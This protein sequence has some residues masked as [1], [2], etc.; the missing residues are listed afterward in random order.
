M[1]ITVAAAAIVVLVVVASVAFIIDQSQP[2]ELLEKPAPGQTK[3]YV[4]ANDTL[5]ALVVVGVIAI[6]LAGLL[7]WVIARR[8]VRPLGE[9]LRMQ[10]TF[11]A[12]A[13]HE[14]RTPVAVVAARAELLRQEN[15][16]GVTSA[17]TVAELQDDVRVLGDVITDLLLAVSPPSEAEPVRRIDVGELVGHTVND[18]RILA[19]ERGVTLAFDVHEQLSTTVPQST[20]RRCVV[21]LVDNAVGHSPSGGIVDVAVGAGRDRSRFELS[22]TDHGTGIL[23]IELDRVFDRFARGHGTTEGAGRVGFGIGLALVRDIADRYGG[24]VA[25]SDTSTQG[26]TLTLSLPRA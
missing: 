10:R 26:T 7:S 14:L 18:L 3:I 11:V 22:V 5:I 19:D 6:V 2:S 20:L 9:A 24:S 13:S 8:A 15:E 23:G 21:A 1:Q 4:D 16:Q 17:R 12:D 25:V